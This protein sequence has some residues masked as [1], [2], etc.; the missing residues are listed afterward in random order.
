MKR[1]NIDLHI[2]SV[3]SPCA[4]LL[5]TPANIIKQAEK[6][7]LDIIAITD[8]NSA[9]NIES[10]LEIA[11]N[12]KVIVI[13]GMEVET[14]EEI[15]LLSFFP[16]LEKI[17]KW[18]KIVYNNLPKIE[19]DEEYFGY[20]IITSSKDEYI[21]K[22]KRMLA[23]ATNLTINQVVKKVRE[24]GGVIIP[25][26][27]DRAY[28]IIKNL[29]F[30]PEEL[31]LKVLEI[32]KNSNSEE[33]KNKFPFLNNYILLKNSDSHYLNEIKIM[34]ETELQEYNFDNLFKNLKCGNFILN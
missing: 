11:K 7:G 1:Y 27:V 18:E 32:S 26:H 21:A 13:P 12:S 34:I 19:N 3:L 10:A 25:S 31:A 16:D 2:H 9:K 5:M 33:I 24:I 4:D 23:T 28:S 15:H 8:H 20:Q 14:S 6:I 30:I 22:E 29:G 17:N